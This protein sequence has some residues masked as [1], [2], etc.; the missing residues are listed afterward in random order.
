MSRSAGDVLR[1]RPAR[2]WA[3]AAL[4]VAALGCGANSVDGAAPFTMQVIP[5]SLSMRL[6]ET[7]GVVVRV[8]AAT[9]TTPRGVP[10]FWSVEHAGIATVSQTGV[11]TA[12]SPGRTR[13]AV[14]LRGQS[15]MVDV[16][17]VEAPVVVVR[18]SAPATFVRA[19]VTIALA[20]EALRADGSAATERPFIW[21]SSSPDAATV[22]SQGAVTGLT[23]GNVIIAA[24]LDGVYGTVVLSVLPTPAHL[25]RVMPE[26]GTLR[27]GESTQFEA[28][29]YDAAGR[30]MNGYPIVWT[31]SE[32]SRVPVSSAGV[33]T[34]I[35]VGTGTITATSE[36]LSATAVVRV[37]AMPVASVSVVP[38]S[39]TLAVGGSGRMVAQ[40][41]GVGGAQLNDR[42]VTWGSDRPGTASVS[43]DGSV[44]AIAEGS[45][46]ITATSEGRSGAAHVLVTRAPVAS[47]TVAP[48]L[49]S[50]TGGGTSRIIATPRGADGVPL[51]NRFITWMAGGPSVATV[52]ATGLVT[53]LAP[54]TA[55]V[56]ASV[57]GQSATTAV[58]VL[59]VRVAAL[60]LTPSTATLPIGQF[61][62]LNVTLLDD[63]GRV[64][65]SVP[66]AWQSSA[67]SVASGGLV[68]A[69]TAGAVRISATVGGVAGFADLVVTSVAPAR[70]RVV[71][72]SLGGTIHV[73]ARYARQVVAQ[74][75][76]AS[77]NPVNAAQVVWSTPGAG[78]A[79]AGA[80]STAL[81][82]ASGTPTPGLLVIATMPGAPPVA[83]TLSL[84]S[85]LVAVAALDVTPSTATM[86]PT[87]AQVVSGVVKDSAGNVVGTASGN[88]LG[89]RA[90]T[91]TSNSGAVLVSPTT[92][93]VTT[94]T[95]LIPG[96]ADVRAVLEGRTATTRITVAPPITVDTIV[97]TSGPSGIKLGVGA[98]STV[99]E[100]FLVLSSGR[101]PI[102]GQS[103]SVSS[104]QA[105]IVV[106]FPSGNAITDG[107]G[108]G[109]FALTLTGRAR[110]GDR[111]DI[112][113]SAGGKR[114][115]WRLT[116]K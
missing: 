98:G 64:M 10:P 2:R 65:P 47:L 41:L 26:A 63:Q 80:G 67:P 104:S 24:A 73:G 85:D 36:G 105:L 21:T 114:T 75:F 42:I 107:R 78:L 38:S 88:P 77:N 34:A 19:G 28:T 79:V 22:S 91:W 58:T 45:A 62:Q 61:V 115:V 95:A 69:L 50:L 106:A 59:P 13:I 113:V 76:D 27:I 82:T 66:V 43:P 20:A 18:V 15:A 102:A 51:G 60:R 1:L 110:K 35:A 6:G 16:A 93:A 33:V 46:L 7:R 111:A 29:L 92:G 31:S 96:S 101:R 5:P 71:I 9:G 90:I 89:Q 68:T 56:V 14:S 70:G 116:V 32:P 97:A 86:G 108:E 74:A 94:V 39:V 103:F 49:L 100:R 44:I 3:L 53:A 81:V 83:D 72:A 55:L 4:S 40:V 84:T 57:E 37:S 87:E 8:L 12:L 112:T 11:V 99:T 48:A 17:V 109:A 23:G 52:D 54:G 25:V 30:E